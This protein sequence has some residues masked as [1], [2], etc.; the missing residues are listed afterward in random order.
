MIFDPSLYLVLDPGF[1]RRRPVED[2]LSEA[3]RGGVTL[4]QIREKNCSR[5]EFLTLATKAAP[6]LRAAGVPLIVNDRVDVALKVQADGVHLGQSDLHWTEARRVLGPQAIIGVSVESEAQVTELETAAVDYLGVSSLFPTP[7][8]IDIKKVWG[9]EGLREVKRLTRHRLVAIGGINVKNAES[10][11][12]A[13]ADGLAL[14]SAIT[15]ADR[16]KTET[17]AFSRLIG[18]FRDSK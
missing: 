16:V 6:I 2:I 3:I 4:V 17:K 5:E 8:K 11:L 12:R 13:G 1:T 15:S 7:T 18:G 9:L 10:A 14:V